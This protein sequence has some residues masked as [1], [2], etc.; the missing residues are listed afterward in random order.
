MP[1][2]T[3]RQVSSP[4]QPPP[5]QPP[6]PTQAPPTTP[7]PIPLQSDLSSTLSQAQTAIQSL[8]S[9]PPVRPQAPALPSPTPYQSPPTLPGSSSV[10]QPHTAATAIQFPSLQ[11]SPPVQQQVPALPPLTPRQSTP[12]RHGSSYLSQAQTAATAIQFPSL[13]RSPVQ[14]PAPALQS[15][16]PHQS[17]PVSSIR[18][19]SA[20]AVE[21]LSV[22]APAPSELQSTRF[23]AEL[24]N[25][26]NLLS[27]VIQNQN[28]LENSRV[29]RQFDERA[30]RSDAYPNPNPNPGTVTV[31]P[32]WNMNDP[33]IMAKLK[34]AAR[35]WS[36]CVAENPRATE[37]DPDLRDAHICSWLIKD[38]VVVS[39]PAILSMLH[40]AGCPPDIDIAFLRAQLKGLRR[41]YTSVIRSAPFNMKSFRKGMNYAGDLETLH[42]IQAP[43]PM[44][45]LLFVILF[46][47]YS[48]F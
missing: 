36:Q 33:L 30:A 47:S 45:E 26:Q 3:R 28:T 7:S 18:S 13:R 22:P 40:Y 12:T 37:D 2:R 21:P 35:L 42:S 6:T 38:G 41:I 31:S 27:V 8:R 24:L 19:R 16:I 1:P 9:S 23:A 34:I 39:C 15:P 46:F 48:F 25:I 17:T 20:A 14:L 10:S 29:L 43:A 32:Q 4:R 44:Y 5:T 11:S